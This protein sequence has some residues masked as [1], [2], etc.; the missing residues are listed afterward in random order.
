MRIIE[1]ELSK[2]I[3]LLFLPAVIWLFVNATVNRHNH[4]LSEDYIISHA[5]PYDKSP[6]GANPA[7]SHDHNEA[8]LFLISLISDPAATATIIFLLL[9]FLIAGYQLLKIHSHLPVMVKELY[10][11]RNYHAP[12]GF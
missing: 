2:S 5:H 12:P 11:V 10:Q 3:L 1:R 6:S 7:G 8:E 4:S 9:L